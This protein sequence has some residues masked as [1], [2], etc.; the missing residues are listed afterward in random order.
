MYYKEHWK[1]YHSC[2][3]DW[4]N[5][6][7]SCS[8]ISVIFTNVSLFGQRRLQPG[9]KWKYLSSSF[10]KYGQSLK[11]ASCIGYPLSIRRKILDFYNWAYYNAFILVLSKDGENTVNAW[12]QG[13]KWQMWCTQL[14]LLIINDICMWSS[15]KM[16]CV[17]NMK[18]LRPISN[19]SIVLYSMSI[20]TKD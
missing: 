8:D 15:C 5:I 19:I 10:I 7:K 9:W 6:Y 14:Y 12:P 3:E 18:S 1:L 4:Y 20:A 17:L 13:F 2:S 16:N 11:F